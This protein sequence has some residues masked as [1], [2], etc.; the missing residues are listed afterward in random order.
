MAKNTPLAKAKAR[1]ANRERKRKKRGMAGLLD[2][3]GMGFIDQEPYITYTGYRSYDRD[4]GEE[5]PPIYVVMEIDAQGNEID[6]EYLDDEGSAEDLARS[7][8][9]GKGVRYVEG[10]MNEYDFFS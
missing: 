10:T 1:R 9:S 4:T 5:L 6:I 2:S 8:A 7:E 3:M